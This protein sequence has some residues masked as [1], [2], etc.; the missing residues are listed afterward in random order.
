[1]LYR[2]CWPPWRE[3]KSWR[4]VIRMLAA[5]MRIVAFGGMST[6]LARFGR[7]STFV[8][9]SGSLSNLIGH[10]GSRGCIEIGCR[11]GFHRTSSGLC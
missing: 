2:F 3:P 5:E 11:N 7:G 1:M 4:A 6:G 8:G 10:P 9:Q